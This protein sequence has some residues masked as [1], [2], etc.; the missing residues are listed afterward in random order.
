MQRNISYRL[1]ELVIQA[2]LKALCF[3]PFFND[4]VQS[5]QPEDNTVYYQNSYESQPYG[6]SYSMPFTYST[7][8]PQTV[9]PVGRADNGSVHY[10]S[11]ISDLTPVSIDLVKKRLQ[12]R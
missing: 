5:S 6:S 1:N 9:K 2:V 12:D 4:Q 3:F 10:G 7:V 11:S 8:T